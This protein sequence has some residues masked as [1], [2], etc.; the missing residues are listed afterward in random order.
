MHTT[1]RQLTMLGAVALLTQYSPVSGATFS[2]ANGDVPGLIAAIQAANATAQEDT[3]QLAIDGD[4]PLYAAYFSSSSVPL[5]RTGLP[6]ITSPVIVEGRGSVIRRAASVAQPV[7]EFRLLR[8]RGRAAALTVRDLGLFNGSAYPVNGDH[9][10]SMGGGI[11]NEGRPLTIENCRFEENRSTHWG[12]A[13]HTTGPTVVKD[14]EFVH[15]NGGDGGTGAIRVMDTSLFIVERCYF[16]K[17]FGQDTIRIEKVQTADISA[18]TIAEATGIDVQAGVLIRE[19]GFRLANCTI[20][21]CRQYGVIIGSS[22]VGTITHCTVY[23]TGNPT[24]TGVGISNGAGSVLS[25]INTIVANSVYVDCQNYGTLLVN[26]GNLIRDGSCNPA[27]IGNP[28]LGAFG[29]YGGPTPVLPLIAG[30]KAIDAANDALGELVDQRGVGRPVGKHWDIGAYEGSIRVPLNST[31]PRVVGAFYDPAPYIVICDPLPD[32]GISL[33]VLGDRTVPARS[34]NPASLTMGNA[35]AGSARVRGIGDVN[36]DGI[37]DLVVE[38]P[39]NSVYLGAVSCEAVTLLEL[40]GETSTGLPIVAYI[41]V[42][43]TGR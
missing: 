15:N 32:E 25:L 8:L 13:V 4:Y 40:Q 7:P 29:Y 3:I 41:N 2:V 19:S 34:I 5:D 43:A 18:S 21:K 1:I 27:L 24:T 31:G 38:F 33:A 16:S 20:Y 42:Q 22:S 9:A 39:L 35:P 28:K 14:S 26:S 37:E 10:D 23:E 11:R 17:N 36:R 12:G 6:W 30:S